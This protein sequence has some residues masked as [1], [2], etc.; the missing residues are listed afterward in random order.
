MNKTYFIPAVKTTLPVFFGY[1]AIGIPFGLMI[2]NAGYPVWLAP[3]MSLTMYAGAGQYIAIGLFATGASLGTIVLT[4]L[5]VNIRH[6]VYGL[7]LI[8]R[9]KNTGKW[10]P[11]LIF[12][13]TDETYSIL[14]GCDVP[15][16]ADTGKYYGIIALLDQSY[17]IAG[18][19]IGAAAGKLIPVSL[20]GVDFALTALFAVLLI[21]QLEK[22]HDFQPAVIGIIV[23]CAAILL[24]HCGIMPSGNILIAALAFGFAALILTRG[25]N[26]GKSTDSEEQK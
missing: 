23:T 18:S 22:S 7:S 24:V 15:N 12:A 21:E 26:L 14:T 13:L 11:Y 8:T 4:E 1:L 19:I 5:L 6:I 2:V 16:G 20:T 9:F 17:W 3:V 25:R 10:K